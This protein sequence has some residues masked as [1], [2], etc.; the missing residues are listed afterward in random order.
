MRINEANLGLAKRTSS[1]ASSKSVDNTISEISLVG[2]EIDDIC[3]DI[4][5]TIKKNIQYKGITFKQSKRTTTNHWNHEETVTYKMFLRFKEYK[6]QSGNLFKPEMV[7]VVTNANDFNWAYREYVD[8]PYIPDKEPKVGLIVFMN[9]KVCTNPTQSSSFFDR[10]IGIIQPKHFEGE[11]FTTISVIVTNFNKLVETLENNPSLYPPSWS[12]KDYTVFTRGIE[13]PNFV[14]PSAGS[15]PTQTNVLNID[16]IKKWLETNEMITYDNDDIDLINTVWRILPYPRDCQIT[17]CGDITMDNVT[18]L[19]PNDEKFDRL[20]NREIQQLVQL[21]QHAKGKVIRVWTGAPYLDFTPESTDILKEKIRGRFGLTLNTWNSKLMPTMTLNDLLRDHED[22]SHVHIV[23]GSE[24]YKRLEDSITSYFRSNRRTNEVKKI[25]ARIIKEVNGQ[26]NESFV[27]QKDKAEVSITNSQGQDTIEPGKHSENV[28]LPDCPFLLGKEQVDWFEYF[29]REK[30]KHTIKDVDDFIASAKK[31][32]KLIK[33]SSLGLAKKTRA[34]A[35]QKDAIDLML[36]LDG[37][38][39]IEDVLTRVMDL[40]N[41]SVT[42]SG[43]KV[44]VRNKKEY[45]DETKTKKIS[46]SWK[47]YTDMSGNVFSPEMVVILTESDMLTWSQGVTDY[48]NYDGAEIPVG[49]SIY[50]NFRICTNPEGKEKLGFNDRRIRLSGP[51][52]VEDSDL[53]DIINLVKNTSKLAEALD[54]DYDLYPLTYTKKGYERLVNGILSPA[55][56][57]PT[58]AEQ[59]SS[60]IVTRE[61]VEKWIKSLIKDNKFNVS[62]LANTITYGTCADPGYIIRE[63]QGM[64]QDGSRSQKIEAI[65]SV[66]HSFLRA[67]RN[68]NTIKDLVRALKKDISEVKALA[69]SYLGLAKKVSSTHEDD[70]SKMTEEIGV[71]SDTD[72]TI[73][74][75]KIDLIDRAPSDW[76]LYNSFRDNQGDFLQFISRSFDG[77]LS[78]RPVGVITF[79]FG[80]NDD[81]VEIESG[82]E[83]LIYP[84]REP[85]T[86][87]STYDECMGEMFNATETFTEE[88]DDFLEFILD[89][90]K[91]DEVIPL[92]DIVKENI[93]RNIKNKS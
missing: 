87:R 67:N 28:Y 62:N 83:N 81:A 91:K 12:K 66:V 71:F 18:E 15:K 1:N 7:F 53:Q 29:Q 77:I 37:C 35:T 89:A 59:D 58:K 19:Y 82:G 45:W 60:L 70:E 36:T 74:K 24:D 86:N 84:L 69:E 41:P 20:T 16:T 32:T 63:I 26:V 6:D 25:A 49:L 61:E 47:G 5:D 13:T 17:F 52:S 90:L 56:E 65:V 68:T 85:D 14:F 76:F 92:T 46:M 8:I 73:M 55:Y 23:R 31:E 93:K 9:W 44:T 51:K 39:D 54:N 3:N 72:S 57:V 34:Q 48:F 42:Y 38:Q 43:L 50:A 10:K 80:L 79:D 21:L 40:I 30:E 75:I 22:M 2:K 33:E 78:S 11:D 27:G 64:T 4:A 88:D